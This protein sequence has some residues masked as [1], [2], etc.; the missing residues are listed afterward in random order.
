MIGKKTLIISAT[1]ASMFILLAV[2]SIPIAAKEKEP[3][4]WEITVPG[5]PEI[6]RGQFLTFSDFEAEK[7]HFGL[8]A[9]DPSGEV[10]TLSAEVDYIKTTGD[11]ENNLHLEAKKLRLLFT[12]GEPPLPIS[13]EVLADKVTVDFFIADEPDPDTGVFGDLTA[14]LEGSVVFRLTV[15]APMPP[16]WAPPPLYENDKFTIHVIFVQPNYDITFAIPGQDPPEPPLILYSDTVWPPSLPVEA[17]VEVTVTPTTILSDPVSIKVET[18]PPDLLSV[19]YDGSEGLPPFTRTIHVRSGRT[20]TW[21]KLVVSLGGQNL[22]PG[23]VSNGILVEVRGH[24]DGY[25][26]PWDVPP[27][28]E[29]TIEALAIGKQWVCNLRFHKKWGFPAS[30]NAVFDFYAEGGLEG[31]LFLRP[32]GEEIPWGQGIPVPDDPTSAIEAD[33]VIYAHEWVEPGTYE[34]GLW[35]KDTAFGEMYNYPVWVTVVE[36]SPAPLFDAVVEP[37]V[38]AVTASQYEDDWQYD[39]TVWVQIDA[40]EGAPPDLRVCLQWD[41]GETGLWGM[42]FTAPDGDPLPGFDWGWVPMEL[43]IN[44][45]LGINSWHVDPLEPPQTFYCWLHVYDGYGGQSHIPLEIT[46][47]AP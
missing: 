7:M 9:V 47:V 2:A 20:C 28:G 38:F 8:P 22:P 23:G 46:V 35:I 12:P 45:V 40:V 21:G 27:G 26:L 1:L 33:V 25:L 41:A 19:D 18:E 11:F 17:T 6:A 42:L 39:D 30:A 24:Y 14:V 43:P 5:Q 3:G 4:Y 34:A 29:P 13:A 16:W 36:E 31:A 44:A 10:A 32:T 37:T 15:D